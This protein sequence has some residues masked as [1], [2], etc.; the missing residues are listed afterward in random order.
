MLGDNAYSIG[1]DDQ[2]QAAV[3]ETYPAT[4]LK[5]VLWP[6]FGNHDGVSASSVTQRGPYYEIFTLPPSSVG[7]VDPF[8]TEAFYSFDFGNIHFISLNSTDIDRSPPPAGEMLDWLEEDLAATVQDWIVAFWHHTPYSKGGHNSDTE[9]ELIQMRQN[10]L[11]VLEA[12][13]VDLVLAGH[14]HGYERSF[15]LDGHYGSSGSLV[16]TMKLA[17]DSDGRIGGD[18][19]FQ[20]ST[21]GPAPHEGTVYVVAGSSGQLTGGSFDHPA[22]FIS[23][24]ELGSVVLDVE[25]DRLEA[26]FLHSVGTVRDTFAIIKGTGILPAADFDASPL[27]GSAPLTVQ[28][29]DLTSTNTAAWAWDFDNDAVVDSAERQPSHLYSASGFYTVS[30]NASNQSGSAVQTKA[31]FICASEGIPP[32]VQNLGLAADSIT[33]GWDPAGAT[34]YDVVKGDLNLLRSTGGGFTAAL[35]GCLEDGGTDLEAVD[36]FGPAPGNGFFYL[37][38]GMSLCGEPGSWD[39]GGASQTVPRDTSVNSSPSSCP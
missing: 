38:R 37:V 16:E 17:G 36:P 30:L 39:S 5:S 34:T 15:F 14:S 12:G 29:Q 20:K 22:I 25:G 35:T 19:P 3:F 9:T 27:V 2:Y 26:T 7:I 28:F 8:Q 32:A 10:A 13:G 24:L 33:I 6:T 23:W 11:P 18:G 31:A 1:T 4:V 21:A